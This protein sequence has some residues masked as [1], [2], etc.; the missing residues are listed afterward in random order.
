MI[1]RRILPLSCLL[2]ACFIFAPGCASETPEPT[3]S[4]GDNDEDDNDDD[5]NDDHDNDDDDEDEAG[6][7]DPQ[8]A[9]DAALSARLNAYIACTN[10]F[11]SG[12]YR[13]RDAYLGYFKDPAAGPARKQKRVYTSSFKLRHTDRVCAD[14]VAKAQAVP[15][16]LPEL[17]KAGDE[18]LAALLALEPLL[19]QAEDY[20]RQENYKDDRFALGRELH[21]QLMQAWAEFARAD[22]ALRE[23]STRLNDE[24][25]DRELILLEGEQ[26]R[27]F[28]FLSQTVM[29]TAK[30]LIRIGSVPDYP[31]LDLERFSGQL[32]TYEAAVK[33][34][35]EYVAENADEVKKLGRVGGLVSSSKTYLIAAKELMRRK[36]DNEKYSRGDRATIRANNAQSVEGHPARVVDAYNKLIDAAN[37]M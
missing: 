27:T 35:E 20:Y 6:K 21:P 9:K 17:D 19:A 4:I 25:Q 16:S 11:S 34:L 12:V 37:R 31:E 36:R 22:E 15:G 13:V 24:R 14:P 1:K 33:E 26:G 23:I 32:G 10:G 8:V 5:D 30:K 7:V 2:T 28:P 29:A 3:E 18:Y